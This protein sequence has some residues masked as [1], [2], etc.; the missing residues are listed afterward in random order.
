MLS[1]A[2]TKKINF[3]LHSLFSSFGKHSVHINNL[4]YTLPMHRL[5][6]FVLCIFYICIMYY[7][8]IR[9]AGATIDARKTSNNYKDFELCKVFMHNFLSQNVVMFPLLLTRRI[10]TFWF[11]SIDKLWSE[12]TRTF[13]HIKPQ[14]YA[15]IYTI[16]QLEIPKIFT[17]FIHNLNFKSLLSYA[18]Q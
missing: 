16:K 17:L 13:W 14:F 2:F 4:F 1:A 5:V 15:W 7:G 12:I 9:A 6:N 18:N 3:P 11:E 10:D 8:G